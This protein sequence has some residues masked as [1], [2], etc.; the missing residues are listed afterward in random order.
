MA[1]V[2]YIVYKTKNKFYVLYTL[3]FK[4]LIVLGDLMFTCCICGKIFENTKYYEPFNDVCSSKCFLEKF[5]KM[6][7]EQYLNG[8]QFIIID[9]CLYSDGG[10]VKNPKDTSLLGFAGRE[11]NIV[12]NDG[13]EIFTNNLWYGGDVPEN[14]KNILCDNAKFI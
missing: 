12:M 2:Q 8:E 6:R 5:W 4:V 7:E 14:H 1:S 11:F 13:T 10:Y 3:S 9:G